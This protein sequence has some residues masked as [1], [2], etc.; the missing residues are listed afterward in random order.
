MTKYIIFRK[1]LLLLF[2]CVNLRNHLKKEMAGTLLLT[3]ENKEPCNKIKF[4]F[5]SPTSFSTSE[6]EASGFITYKKYVEWKR[7]SLYKYLKKYFLA[8]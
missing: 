4:I 2:D 7:K 8:L 5:T 1:Q 6:I 3:N